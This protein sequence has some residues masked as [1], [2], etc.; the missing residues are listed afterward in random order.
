MLEDEKFLDIVVDMMLESDGRK[1]GFDPWTQSA[2]RALKRGEKPVA[3]AC[4]QRMVRQPR[5][6]EAVGGC[7]QQIRPSWDLDRTD[8][9]PFNV[10]AAYGAYTNVEYRKRYRPTEL[11]DEL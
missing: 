11:D 8:L 5:S 6:H 3:S 1:S 10:D 2:R 9:Q 4:L 7:A